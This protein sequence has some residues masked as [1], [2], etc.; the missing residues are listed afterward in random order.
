MIFLRYILLLASCSLASWGKLSLPMDINERRDFL[1]SVEAEED[2][3]DKVSRRLSLPAS[4][5]TPTP[6]HPDV[7]STPTT[8]KSRVP[9][10]AGPTTRSSRK[11]RISQNSANSLDMSDSGQ[12]PGKR[13]SRDDGAMFAK[14]EAMISG[15][16]S[17]IAKSEANTAARIDS[18]LDDVSDKF[19]A[20]L[21]TTEATVASLGTDVA[22][23]QSEILTMKKKADTQAR[24]LSA[25][26][27]DI[28]TRKL[29]TNPNPA[30]LPRP[31]TTSANTF[32]KKYWLARRSLRVWPIPG[33]DYELSLLQFVI[34]RLKIPAGRIERGEFTVVPVIST[35]VNNVKDQVI[36]TFDS[37]RTRDELK[38]AARNL[39]GTDRSVGLQLEAPDHLRS[40]YQAFQKLGFQIKSKHPALKRNVKFDDVDM[41]LVMDIQ[42]SS[43]ADWKTITYVEA[44]GLLKRAKKVPWAIN[45]KAELDSL[46]NLAT[47]PAKPDAIALSDSDDDYSDAIVIPE[48]D[49]KDD[50]CSRYLSFLNA[51]ARSLAPK[52]ESLS[53]CFTEK[54]C[55]LAFLTET[56]FQDNRDQFQNLRDYADRFSL[57]IINRN[58]A[59]CATNLRQYGGVA[60]AYRFKTSKFEE[61]VLTNPL[62]H[63]V[64]AAVGK[65]VGIRGKVFCLACY[66][67]PN[68]T[69]SRADL[70]LEYISDVISEGK[71]RFKDCTLIICGDFNQWPA[72]KLIDDHPDLTEIVH[73]PTRGN[74]SIDRSFV[75]FGRSVI[76]ADT[77][78]PLETEERIKS[79]HRIGWAKAVF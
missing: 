71:R 46:V 72:E 10:S 48:N 5:E 15:V 39:S 7:K 23:M 73:G 60:I 53:D 17:D 3:L 33:P 69:Q 12:A 35:G 32:E 4:S 55:D 65:V 26:V 52:I 31:L 47:S 38:S 79:D 40:H 68:L 56:W 16:R 44:R 34:E 42:T 43:T 21:S 70:L 54:D 18:K 64:V 45:S 22:R 63:E 50:K 78:E 59:I 8:S 30:P 66:A 6:D 14:L 41:A 62:E 24:S 28:V 57:G 58:R 67:P 2:W 19:T 37:I 77:L 74:R 76:E 27:E 9:A 75:N 25:V 11:R 1:A 36:V 29:S 51:N 61:F 20:R 13:S 49:N